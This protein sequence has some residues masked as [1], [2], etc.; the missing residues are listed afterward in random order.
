LKENAFSGTL[1]PWQNA[2]Q[3]VYL[4]KNLIRQMITTTDAADS[5]SLTTG[6]LYTAGC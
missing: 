6:M 4:A 1:C 5:N 3:K 2:G